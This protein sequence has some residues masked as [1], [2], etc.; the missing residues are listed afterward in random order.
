MQT[1]EEKKSL[2]GLRLLLVEDN[3]INQ[4]VALRY[5]QKW[6]IEADL[7][8]NGL[9]CL[10]KIREK[11]YDIILMDLQMPEMDGYTAAIE[12][13]KNEEIKYKE[14]PIIALSATALLDTKQKVQQA[15]MTDYIAKPFVPNEL[16]TIIEQ[17]YKK[18]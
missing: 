8:E 4:K 5:L 15:G 10:Q 17:Y 16:F 18:K 11:D 3:I 1:N 9:I 14:I 12:I 6:E 13:R 2:R 7:A